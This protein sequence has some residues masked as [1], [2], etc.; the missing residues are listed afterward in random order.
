[1][2]AVVGVGFGEGVLVGA[3]VG[4]A[5]LVGSFVG[6]FVGVFGALVGTFVG[7]KVGGFVGALVGTLV[8][9]CVGACPSVGVNSPTPVG[10][11]SPLGVGESEGT[12]VGLSLGTGV[13]L[14][15]GTA[16]SVGVAVTG[17]PEGSLCAILPDS[18]S[19]LAPF[20]VASVGLLSDL[21]EGINQMNVAKTNTITAIEVRVIIDFFKRY[22][23]FVTSSTIK[24][25]PFER[26]RIKVSVPEK[27]P[28]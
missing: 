21:S 15:D 6:A 25:C 9:A 7:D 8:G 2:G 16:S 1:M 5:A 24:H 11:G 12:G 27:L 23:P 14:S 20:F 26:L 19:M 17:L 4:V 28:T 18:P 22:S 3:C 10:E 13:G